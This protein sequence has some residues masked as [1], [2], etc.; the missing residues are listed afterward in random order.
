MRRPIS[1]WTSKQWVRMLF[2]L[3]F[4]VGVWIGLRYILCD[5]NEAI[6][7]TTALILLWYT[8]ETC[9]LRWQM[10]RQNELTIR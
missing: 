10:V 3:V 7:A 5:K 1:G 4:F 8:V 6:L 9:A 2:A